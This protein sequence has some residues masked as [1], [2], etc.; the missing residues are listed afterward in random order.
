LTANYSYT[1]EQRYTPTLGSDV[2]ADDSK[3]AIEGAYGLVSGK[4]SYIS[5]NQ[6]WEVSLWGTNLTDEQYLA[7]RGT[8]AAAFGFVYGR[9]G[10]PR[11]Y[12]A[13]VKYSY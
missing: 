1:G 8:P 3:L 11:M 12:G 13:E 5:E 7:E 2:I 9:M 10:A 6:D 4:I